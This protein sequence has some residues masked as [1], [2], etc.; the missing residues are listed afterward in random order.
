MPRWSPSIEVHEWFY[1]L[2]NDWRRMLRSSKTPAEAT[3]AI[4]SA[5]ADSLDEDPMCSIFYLMLAHY[6]CRDRCLQPGVRRK[7][8]AIIRRGAKHILWVNTAKGTIARREV[9][10]ERLRQQILSQ[11]TVRS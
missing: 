5:N 10:F 3:R 11:S 4:I 6:Q 9:D 1:G 7:A 2:R 8:L